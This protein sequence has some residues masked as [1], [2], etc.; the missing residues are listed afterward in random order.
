MRRRAEVRTDLGWVAIP[1]RDAD[2]AY[3]E[4]LLAP[5]ADEIAVGRQLE[6]IYGLPVRFVDVP[7]VTS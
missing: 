5:G 6:T 3:R 4:A 7:E 1:V 2:G